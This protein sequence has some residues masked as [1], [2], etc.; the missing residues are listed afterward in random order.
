[1]R[2]HGEVR[3]RMAATGGNEQTR[4]KDH[5]SQ[6]S[7]VWPSRGTVAGTSQA[8]IRSESKS[9]TAD[10]YMRETFT[11]AVSASPFRVTIMA[12]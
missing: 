6:T 8:T 11:V 2:G 9:G 4:S 3:C 7:A 1:M 10:A 5:T 12:S